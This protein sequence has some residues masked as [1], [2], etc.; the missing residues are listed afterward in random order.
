VPS[1]ITG[2][3]LFLVH[4]CMQ[5]YSVLLLTNVCYDHH[6]GCFLT[7]LHVFTVCNVL[8]ASLRSCFFFSLLIQMKHATSNSYVFIFFIEVVVKYNSYD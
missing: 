1:I 4:C 5:L 2:A 6:D 3:V 8:L 7:S